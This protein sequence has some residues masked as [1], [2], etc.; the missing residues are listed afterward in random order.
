MTH[1]IAII[2]DAGP[3]HAVGVWFPDLPGCFSA[4]DDI[5]QALLNAPEALEL[6][7]E[8]Q[9]A[10]GRALPTPRTLTELRNDPSVADDIKTYMVAV[11]ELPTRAH[12]AE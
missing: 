5:D 4:G 2:E 7:A 8:G 3:D 9:I 1:Y 6:Y 11:I 10:E 12:A